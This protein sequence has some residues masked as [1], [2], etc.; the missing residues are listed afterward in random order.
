MLGNLSI[1]FITPFPCHYFP[2]HYHF[3]I[4]PPNY[5]F[6]FH[7]SYFYFP[8][9]LLHFPS[10]SHTFIPLITPILYYF[11]LCT[12]SSS[13]FPFSLPFN[14][15]PPPPPRFLSLPPTPHPFTP[16]RLISFQQVSPRIHTPITKYWRMIWTKFRMPLSGSCRKTPQTGKKAAVKQFLSKACSKYH[17]IRGQ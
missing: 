10:Y 8:S 16:C 1:P 9:T 12:L 13:S 6:T 14:C 7:S 17:K 15:H 2:F 11:L 5:S 4:F 3:I